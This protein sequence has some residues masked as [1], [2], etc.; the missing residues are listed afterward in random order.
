[1]L[2]REYALQ[3]QSK[4]RR[5]AAARYARAIRSQ[6]QRRRIAESHQSPVPQ[7]DQPIPRV[8]PAY[9][10]PFHNPAADLTARTA[11]IR[12][13][14]TAPKIGTLSDQ[15]PSSATILASHSRGAGKEA[16]QALADRISK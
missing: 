13:E 5:V 6:K 10:K 14:N 9:A 1:M 3:R 12:R 15:S 16:L 8:Q 7:Q 4:L 11:G 2:Q